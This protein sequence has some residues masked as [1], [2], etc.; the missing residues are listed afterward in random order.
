MT[1]LLCPKCQQLLDAPTETSPL[2]TCSGCQGAWAAAIEFD[3]ATRKRREL[4][5]AARQTGQAVA[6]TCP[7]CP[8]LALSE[9]RFGRCSLDVC[10]SCE[11]VF[12]DR[13][14]W[15]RATKDMAGQ[16]TLGF[17]V[18]EAIIEGV[19]WLIAAAGDA[20]G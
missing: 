7:L 11:G 15:H 13:G 18:G 4:V 12:F 1:E 2:A 8:D 19:C 9:V 14:E 6:A 16:S 17:V 3:K 5:D 10:L 20:L